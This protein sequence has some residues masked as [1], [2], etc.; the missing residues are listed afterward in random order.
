MG[1]DDNDDG[2]G[3]G[4]GEDEDEGEEYG[5]LL[6]FLLSLFVGDVMIVTVVFLQFLFIRARFMSEMR[7]A[8]AVLLTFSSFL[9]SFPFS[10]LPFSSLRQG[11]NQ[12]YI[13]C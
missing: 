10:L 3:D 12:P 13:F 11:T 8:M 6:I 1:D 9:S 7:A 4:D 5:F 2:D